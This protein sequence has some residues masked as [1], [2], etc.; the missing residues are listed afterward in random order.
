MKL[1][2]NCKNY[3]RASTDGKGELDRKGRDDEK[4]KQIPESSYP[5]F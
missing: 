4:Y 5:S 1:C 3:R 2:I